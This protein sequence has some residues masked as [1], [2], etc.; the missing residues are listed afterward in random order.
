MAHTNSNILIVPD[1]CSLI[2]PKLHVLA[3]I[4]RAAWLLQNECVGEFVIAVLDWSLGQVLIYKWIYGWKAPCEFYW[5]K[6]AT[7]TPNHVTSFRLKDTVFGR[8][9]PM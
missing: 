6:A 8:N 3:F 4:L 1:A 2:C 9:A 7:T 5:R